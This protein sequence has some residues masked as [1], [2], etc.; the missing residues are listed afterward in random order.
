ML[1]IGNFWNRR[2][3]IDEIS[4]RR[5]KPWNLIIFVGALCVLLCCFVQVFAFVHVCLFLARAFI[6]FMFTCM[7][8]L[9]IINV[10]VFVCLCMYFVIVFR[11]SYACVYVCCYTCVCVCAC[12]FVFVFL[13]LWLWMC[14]F[15]DCD[16]ACVVLILLLV[17]ILVL[18]PVS[19]WLWYIFCPLVPKFVN[20]YLCLYAY[21]CVYARASAL[22]SCA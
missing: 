9:W 7:R 17:V 12:L 20:M 2:L 11:N 15:C 22:F 19:L 3:L 16:C 1:V 8:F 13:W 18:V 14:L 5:A 10:I 6:L 21:A 4:L